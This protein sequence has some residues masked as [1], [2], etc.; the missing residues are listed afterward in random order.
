MSHHSKLV[1]LAVAF[2]AQC[3]SLLA[4]ATPDQRRW[5]LLIGINEY[6]EI[7][8]LTYAAAD[9]IS[10][11]DRLIKGGFPADQVILM[12]DDATPKKYL[13]T[14]F[15]IEKQLELVLGLVD[16]CDV[17]VIGFSG[18]GL[19]LNGKSYLCPID[20]Q[21]NGFDT[22]VSIENIYNQLESSEASFKLCLFDACRSDPFKSGSKASRKAADISSFTKTLHT[23]PQG[24]IVLSSCDAGQVSFEDPTV[25][26]GIFLY[27]L[28]QGW[29]GPADANSDS[30][31]TLH[32][33]FKHAANH[34]KKHAQQKYNQLQVPKLRGDVTFE[35]FEFPLALLHAETTTPAISTRDDRAD[36]NAASEVLEVNNEPTP[37]SDRDS[38]LDELIR[39]ASLAHQE[40]RHD[41]ARRLVDAA[42]KLCPPNTQLELKFRYLAS[43]DLVALED[44]DAYGKSL[45]R[46]Q[47]LIVTLPPTTE[48]VASSDY[49]RGLSGEARVLEIKGE[50]AKALILLEEFLRGSSTRDVG[51]RHFRLAEFL[52]T[53]PELSFRD[54]KRAVEIIE[55]FRL[56]CTP[57]D[58]S[59]LAAAYAECGRFTDAVTLQKE[60]IEELRKDSPPNLEGL[61][62]ANAI[63][64]RYESGKRYPSKD[65]K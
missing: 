1:V 49:P 41:E 56:Y 5:A 52:A 53:C 18:H 4:Q 15:N 7:N 28:T 2:A 58:L 42:L 55:A 11:R 9:M 19:H 27:Y 38:E 45:E 64:E 62:E 51:A 23:A 33:A 16:K 59:R 39:K 63:L 8:P 24:V 17:L 48:R 44:Y 10:L 47:E 26:H 29:D 25:G 57:G 34:T 65:D 32:E 36:V 50:Y 54:G 20:T 43:A 31:V 21:S 13:P 46:I 30:V 61:K 12:H 37:N 3:G 60:F 6:T 40:K 14:K 22:L 35:A